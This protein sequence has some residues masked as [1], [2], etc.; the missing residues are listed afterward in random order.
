MVWCGFD[1]RM[2]SGIVMYADG[3][4][5]AIC[6][7]AQETGVSNEVQLARE[8]DELRILE[9]LVNQRLLAKEDTYS[10]QLQL[11]AFAGMIAIA[12]LFIEASNASTEIDQ[13][14]DTT[15]YGLGTLIHEFDSYYATLPKDLDHPINAKTTLDVV[16]PKVTLSSSGMRHVA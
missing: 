15:A 3:V 2:R 6:T 13:G 5:R 8:R 10:V 4:A 1:V 12:R 11:G 16:I 7:K 14:F 9:A